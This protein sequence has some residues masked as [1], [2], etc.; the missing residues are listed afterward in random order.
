[1]TWSI[2]SA[3]LVVIIIFEMI[4]FSDA[5]LVELLCVV[6]ILFLLECYLYFLLP[7]IR[8]KALAKMKEVENEYIFFDNVLKTFTKSQEYN[9]EAEIEYSLFVRVYETTK[10][11]FLYQTNNQVFIVDKSTI[12]GGTIEDVRNKLTAFVKDKYIICKY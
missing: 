3:I 4:V 7:K 1:M 10:H 6:I 8:Y 5:M 12:D 2:I 11:L 9:G